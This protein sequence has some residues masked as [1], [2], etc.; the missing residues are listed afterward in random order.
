MSI[1]ATYVSNNNCSF[2]SSGMLCK[3]CKMP[4]MSNRIN[5]V[6]CIFKI[7]IATR[8]K[9]ISPSYKYKSHLAIQQSEQN[10]QSNRTN[11]KKPKKANRKKPRNDISI[12]D[13]AKYHTHQTEPSYTRAA[14]S[15][16]MDLEY[17]VNNQSIMY[18]SLCT[19]SR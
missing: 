14:T 15:N 16:G 11:R 4:P 5:I 3:K 7:P 6:T 12:V 1:L 18:I 19:S 17:N 2:M 9:L 10:E 13:S 8:N